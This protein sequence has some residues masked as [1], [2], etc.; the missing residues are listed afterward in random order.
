MVAHQLWCKYQQK[1]E[2]FRGS[3]FKADAVA[4]PPLFHKGAV[5]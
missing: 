1:F 2:S 3:N 5:A 4:H